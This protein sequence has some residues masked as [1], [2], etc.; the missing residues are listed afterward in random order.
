MRLPMIALPLQPA[1]A[2][3]LHPPAAAQLRLPVGLIAE[4]RPPRYPPPVPRQQTPLF[5]AA[6]RA[7]TPAVVLTIGAEPEP[8]SALVAPPALVVPIRV[9]AAPHV[10]SVAAALN[11]T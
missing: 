5:A 9:P 7:C 3:P 11:P 4:T 6:R 10:A 8:L 2:L 1:H